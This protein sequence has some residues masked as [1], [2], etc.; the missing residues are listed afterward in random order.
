MK[1][2]MRFI[3][4]NILVHAFTFGPRKG[5][6]ME[7]LKGDECFVSSPL[8]LSE[9][10]SILF[11]ITKNK[12][13][14][15]SIIT[16]IIKNPQFSFVSIDKNIAF[17]AVSHMN[18]YDLHFNDACHYATAVACGCEAIVSYDKDFDGMPLKR[19]EP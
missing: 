13:F 1:K 15:H 6:C 4:T 11:R 16:E 2:I 17:E 10:F 18:K 5:A 12:Q 3:D 14:C 19:I 9:L 7:V 8:I